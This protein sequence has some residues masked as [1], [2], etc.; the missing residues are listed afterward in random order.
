MTAAHT[1]CADDPAVWT[2]LNL[3]ASV[4]ELLTFPGK[5]RLKNDVY[6]K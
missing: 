3:P 6:N 5:W 2:N 1:W 4:Y